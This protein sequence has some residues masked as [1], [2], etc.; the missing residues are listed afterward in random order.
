MSE[1]S[2]RASLLARSCL[3]RSTS[4]SPS[5]T[6]A[7][8]Y[9]R[10]AGRLAEPAACVEAPGGAGVDRGNAGADTGDAG[11]GIGDAGA[12]TGDAG[13][14]MGDA[15]TVTGL[16]G[17]TCGTGAGAPQPAMCSNPRV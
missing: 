14:D 1:A 16:A 3:A 15:G 13:A 7:E 11:A 2:T 12:E 4:E 17:S 9:A 6:P 10:S 8:V 5:G